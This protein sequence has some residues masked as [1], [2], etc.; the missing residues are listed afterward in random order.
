M[1]KYVILGAGPAGLAFANLLLQ[2][3]ETDFVVLEKE[4]SAGGLCRSIVVDDAP[5][6]IGGGHFL[7]VRRPK[8]NSFL[9]GFMPEHEWNIF[10]RDSR[11]QINGFLIG[12]PIEANIWQFPEEQQVEYL[13]SI[14][15]AGCNLNEEKPESFVNWIYWKLGKKIAE[16]Y[17]IPYNQK[18]FGE[19]LNRL[20]AYWLEKL[21]NVS[22]DETLLSCLKRRPYGSQPGHARFYYP[23]EQGYGELWLRMANA[24]DQ[25]VI[26]NSEISKINFDEHIVTTKTG[27]QFYGET[28]ITTI[29]WTSVNQ[30]VGMP[31]DIENSVSKLKHT[32]IVTEYEN[33]SMNTEAHWIY[34]PSLDVQYHRMLMR[35]NFCLNSRGQWTETNLERWVDRQNANS[36]VNRYAYPVN[37]IEKPAIMSNLLAWAC[38][39]KVYGLGRWGEHQHYNSDAVVERAMKLF[40]EIA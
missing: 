21:P 5:F 37:T 29:P 39:R 33:N 9:F 1:N 38:T 15:V 32:G 20:G 10:E 31:T 14:A 24:L 22:F 16:D 11:I 19:N 2:S 28:I 23:K 18:M 7:D 26:Y 17:M 34:Y 40:G 13:K 27:E 3:G 8:A 30:F 36:F 6:D 4:T 25:R 35:H 12:H